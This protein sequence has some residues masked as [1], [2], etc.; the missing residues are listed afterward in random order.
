MP[1]YISTG[2]LPTDILTVRCVTVKQG[3]FHDPMISR[4]NSRCNDAS[5]QERTEV[6]Y[7]ERRQ[8]SNRIGYHGIALAAAE[9]RRHV[10][11]AIRLVMPA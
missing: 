3:S 7:P 4:A 1:E 5:S 2:T 9:L 6:R 11:H 10:N 8:A